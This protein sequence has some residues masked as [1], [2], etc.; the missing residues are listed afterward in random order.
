VHDPVL[1]D[2]LGGVGLQGHQGLIDQLV[3]PGAHRRKNNLIQQGRH[4]QVAITLQG[5]L[6]L[7]GE[8]SGPAAHDRDSSLPPHGAATI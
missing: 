5:L 3:Q 4:Q 7:R 8:Q 1:L 2:V 6:L